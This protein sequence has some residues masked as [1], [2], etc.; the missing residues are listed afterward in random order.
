MQHYDIIIAGGGAAGLSLAYRL[1]LSPLRNLTILI[2][3][4]DDNDQMT[5][6]WGFWTARPTLFDQVAHHAWRQ[7]DFVTADTQ[8]RL[9]L[10]A[11]EYRLMH[12]ADFYRF[13]LAQ[14]AACPNVTFM[15]GVVGQITDGDAAAQVVVNDDA[16]SGGWVFDS[17]VHPAEMC[18][19][20]GR[21]VLL[22]MHFKGW[23]IETAGPAFDATAARLFDLRTAQR[24]ALRFLYLMPY[25]ERRAFIEYTV[26]SADVLRQQEYDEALKTYIESVLG[27]RAYSVA[28]R[29][30]G[31]VPVTDY[32]FPRRAAA[33]VVNI[34]AKGGRIKP[35]TG[36]SF[37]RIQDDS[38]AIIKSLLAN[39]HPFD[40]PSGGRFYRACD[41]LLLRVM[42][43]HGEAIETIYR[44]LFRRN[45]IQRVLR[46]LDEESSPLE[47]AALIATLPP[48]RFLQAAFQ[49]PRR[50][51]KNA[52][53]SAR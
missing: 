14:L 50:E 49:L 7:L 39:G 11:Y 22:R 30:A 4:K 52:I 36:Y 3:D 17:I 13:V 5:R 16:V 23:E 12:G 26:F 45:P 15:K 43:D 10:G 21:H 28:S 8:L 24:G 53:Q 48:L 2:I 37:M 9:E 40:V 38:A 41:S 33:H 34:G 25:T 42:A 6:N 51:R 35:S 44:H 19:L 29:E 18:R 47:T 20:S 1:M 27:I 46:F 31:V 32:R